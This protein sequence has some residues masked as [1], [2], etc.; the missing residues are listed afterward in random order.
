MH[1]FEFGNF[2]QI[3]KY[4]ICGHVANF[5]PNSLENY[6]IITVNFN[7]IYFLIKRFFFFLILHNEF[8]HKTFTFQF[9]FFETYTAILFEIEKIAH[10][11]SVGNKKKKQ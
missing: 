8:V 10:Q 2:P 7:F 3:Q 1:L 5:T 11:K 6:A 9:F 4:E